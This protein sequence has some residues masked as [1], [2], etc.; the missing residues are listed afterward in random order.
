MHLQF[1]G[2]GVRRN[3]SPVVHVPTLTSIV[4][5]CVVIGRVC[6]WCN[7]L[8]VLTRTLIH[9]SYGDEEIRKKGEV[10]LWDVPD[11]FQ[12]SLLTGRWH[13][14]LSYRTALHYELYQSPRDVKVIHI[15]MMC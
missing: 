2:L 10:R 13:T 8:Q 5:S 6:H 7:R 4:T 3:N 14:P 11:E 9:G 12:L 1:S 15:V